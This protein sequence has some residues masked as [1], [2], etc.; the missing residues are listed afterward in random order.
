M[1]LPE[2]IFQIR[3]LLDDEGKLRLTQT[4]Q[5]PSAPL[6]SSEP[7]E[8][9]S[10]ELLFRGDARGEGSNG[11]L[12]Q[13]TQRL[14]AEQPHLQ[15]TFFCKPV[16]QQ[17]LPSAVYLP[18]PVAQTTSVVLPRCAT[19]VLMHQIIMKLPRTEHPIVTAMP[20]SETQEVPMFVPASIPWTSL[21]HMQ[22]WRMKE[23]VYIPRK[24]DLSEAECE[25][26]MRPLA[27]MIAQSC[28]D[29]A[30]EP[31]TPWSLQHNGQH[32]E[33]AV[34]APAV[35]A[36]LVAAEVLQE[37]P[38]RQAWWITAFG[39]DQLIPCV[40]LEQLPPQKRRAFA[41]RD[42]AMQD[43]TVLELLLCP[44]KSSLADQH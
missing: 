41:P 43:W 19:P 2:C 7:V 35:L 9:L 10:D 8:A 20:H 22:R 29:T 13:V 15:S 38:S 21:Q 32:L 25:F 34:E 30:G 26:V 28:V 6:G 44:I 11:G 5:A 33:H 36:K 27:A 12:P 16:T 14:Y 18:L 4:E 42:V 17:H 23:V 31:P 3:E 24:P 40:V 37:T 39:R 1:Y